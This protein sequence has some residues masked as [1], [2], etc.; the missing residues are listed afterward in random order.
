MSDGSRRGVRERESEEEKESLRNDCRFIPVR[1]VGHD[2]CMLSLF[3]SKSH[4]GLLPSSQLALPAI[5]MV[6][7][8]GMVIHPPEGHEK[9]CEEKRRS[10]SQEDQD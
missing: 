1:E 9:V 2:R 3:R 4:G 5:L 10:V 7:M 8:M 6:M